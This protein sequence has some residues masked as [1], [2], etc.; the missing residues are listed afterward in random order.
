LNVGI[1][2]VV[3]LSSTQWLKCCLSKMKNKRY[4]TG[5]PHM[6]FLS[7]EVPTATPPW[8]SIIPTECEEYCAHRSLT[9]RNLRHEFFL[10]CIICRCSIIPEGHDRWNAFSKDGAAILQGRSVAWLAFS[11]TLFGGSIQVALEIVEPLSFP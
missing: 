3:I 1:K 11:T 8:E 4:S 7:F 10:F 9:G 5:E 6:I 2:F